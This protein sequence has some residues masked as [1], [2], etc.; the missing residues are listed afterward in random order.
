MTVQKRH[1]PCNRLDYFKR[2]L[3]GQRSASLHNV[4]QRAAVEIFHHIVD[5]VVCLKHLADRHNIVH[6]PAQG[7]Q[8]LRL[9]QEVLAALLH[10]RLRRTRIHHTRRPGIALAGV[11]QEMLL[12]GEM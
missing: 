3:L 6:L 12:H 4:A 9:R 10:A 8:T 1:S 7:I 2:T 5:R 11:L